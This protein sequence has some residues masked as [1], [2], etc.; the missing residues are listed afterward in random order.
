MPELIEPPQLLLAKQPVKKLLAR[1]LGISRWHTY[2]LIDPSGY[3]DAI[4][5]GL[6]DTRSQLAERVAKYVHVSVPAL[7]AFYARHKSAAA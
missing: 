7:R 4:P 2:G 6:F 1:E 3:P 5:A